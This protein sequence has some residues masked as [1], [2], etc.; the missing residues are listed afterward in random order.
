[1]EIAHALRR[2]GKHPLLLA[3]GVLVAVA[4]AILSVYRIDDGS[5]KARSLQHSAATTQVLVD[6]EPSSLGSVSESFEALSA[7]AEVYANFMTSP[8]LLEVIARQVHLS[9]SQLYA[10]GPVNAAEPRVE[11][12]PTALKRNVEITGETKPYRLNF[13]SQANLPTI[14]I[15][16]QAPTT[17]QAVELAN[18]AAVGLKRYVADVATTERI[19]KHSRVVIR[20]LGPATGGVVDGGISR[21]LAVMVFVLVM[22]LWCVLMLA[23]SRARELWR[24]SAPEPGEDPDSAWSELPSHQGN[25]RMSEEEVHL[26]GILH[27]PDDADF[28]TVPDSA[29]DHP[30]SVPEPD[31][32]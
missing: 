21:T 24:A 30:A 10:A 20:Q 9:A 15:N 26:G 13:E 29:E 12:E 28:A 19:G 25:G 5:L 3:L 16:S 32:R 22:V 1:M 11:Q 27:D 2:L 31:M 8:T 23:A 17:T 4:A 18:A 14:T 7:R 6:S